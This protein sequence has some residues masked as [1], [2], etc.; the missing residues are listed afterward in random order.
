M[1]QVSFS[2][3]VNYQKRMELEAILAS[4]DT[5]TFEREIH[6]STDHN[7]KNHELSNRR[8]KHKRSLK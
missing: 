3:T 7:E 6:R 5:H 4:S 8:I 1:N 2:G